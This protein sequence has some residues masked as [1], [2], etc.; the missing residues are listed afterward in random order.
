MSV[1]RVST[2]APAR[3]ASGEI[4]MDGLFTGMLGALVVALWFLILDLISGRPLYTPALLGTMLLHGGTA[5]AGTITIAPLEIAAYTA[6]HFITFVIVGT[7]FSWL[8]SLFDRFPI[9]FFVILVLAAC[10]QI[11]FVAFSL[12]LHFEAPMR[13]GL[14]SVIVANLL[15][16]AAMGIYQAR[17]HPGALKGVERLWEHT[18]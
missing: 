2:A 16:A 17:R 18:D 4:L 15:A 14:W 10:L 9:M 6:F 11:G 1:D 3:Q 12:A 8:M 5:A 13:L 7:A